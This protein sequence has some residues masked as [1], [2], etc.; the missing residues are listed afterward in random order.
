M[1]H[2]LSKLYTTT[3]DNGTSGLADGSRVDKWQPI[4]HAMGA[5]DEANSHLGELIALMDSSST[6][7]KQFS[8]LQHLL[9][10]VGGELAMPDYALISSADVEALESQIDAL[11]EQLPPLKE[12][13]LPGGSVAAAKAH[14]V[15]SVLRRAER[16]AFEA[17][18]GQPKHENL[19]KW[20]NR[21]S[22]YFF[23]AARLIARE[24][25]SEVLW[26][27]PTKA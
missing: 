17:L 16:Y 11:N 27:N 8:G 22:D 24:S 10:N 15:R 1:G 5:V 13:V 25:G 20:L 2:R 19:C 14:V 6:L 9:F 12:F 23:A 3:G 4:M 21:S 26:E 7:T 18:I